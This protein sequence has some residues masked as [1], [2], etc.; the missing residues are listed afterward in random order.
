MKSGREWELIKG[1]PVFVA[2]NFSVK[3]SWRET[4]SK[5]NQ[6]K[7]ATSAL[8]FFTWL[9]RTKFSI[10]FRKHCKVY[11]LIITCL[12]SQSNGLPFAHIQSQSDH[13]ILQRSLLPTA[14]INPLNCCRLAFLDVPS[15]YYLHSILISFSSLFP[16]WLK[17][18]LADV[19]GTCST[20]LRSLPKSHILAKLCHDIPI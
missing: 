10:E 11:I 19:H 3:R 8:C 4:A 12:R 20:C 9:S 1:R 2:E 18:L 17:L 13:D 14:F 5:G 6:D 7:V 16:L 15:M